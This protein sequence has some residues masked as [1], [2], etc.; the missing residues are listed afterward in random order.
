MSN[1]LLDILDRMARERERGLTPSY[2]HGPAPAPTAIRSPRVHDLRDSGMHPYDATQVT[3]GISTGD[4]L[5]AEDGIGVMMEAWPIHVGGDAE[6]TGFHELSADADIRQLGQRGWGRFTRYNWGPHP[7]TGEHGTAEDY[8]AP[9]GG[10]DLT[11]SFRLARKLTGACGC[12]ADRNCKFV[13]S[14]GMD[15]CIRP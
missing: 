11:E 1:H 14:M 6:R 10:Y 13:R 5:I 2:V 15:P 8:S 12:T 9:E 7:E 4:I 3:D